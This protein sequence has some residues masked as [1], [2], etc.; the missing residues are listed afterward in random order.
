MFNKNETDQ[1]YYSGYVCQ[2]KFNYMPLLFLDPEDEMFD[3]VCTNWKTTRS[4]TWMYK[5][6]Q[7]E[8]VE[9][10]FMNDYLKLICIMANVL[11]AAG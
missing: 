1:Y 5:L 4:T 6:I 11:C 7:S 10:T 9:V 3:L 2:E 8:C